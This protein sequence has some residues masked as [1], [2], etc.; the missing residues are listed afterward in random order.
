MEVE[1]AC[2]ESDHSVE[3]WTYMTMKIP[4]I[5]RKEKKMKNRLQMRK[6]KMLFMMMIQTERGGERR[7]EE[8]IEDGEDDEEEEGQE[9][10]YDECKPAGHEHPASNWKA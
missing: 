6:G 10:I 7:E 3:T 4:C 9:D 5:T 1:D 8:D 2:S